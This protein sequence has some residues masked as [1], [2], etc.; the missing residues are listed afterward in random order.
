[1]QINNKTTIVLLSI[2]LLISINYVDIVKSAGVGVAP[3]QIIMDNKLKGTSYLKSIRLFNNGDE[4][5]T[6]ELN[7]T[8]DIIPWVTIYKTSELIESIHNLSKFSTL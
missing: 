5:V 1:M 3:A 4:P 7:V 8:G 6:F 2:F